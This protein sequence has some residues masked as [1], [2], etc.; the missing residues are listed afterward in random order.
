MSYHQDCVDALEKLA[1]MMPLT[2]REIKV[3]RIMVWA[4]E[5]DA[6]GMLRRYPKDTG[7]KALKMLAKILGDDAG[8]Q[9]SPGGAGQP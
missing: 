5:E 8:D 3:A 6:V 2:E 7:E 1:A 9:P 4:M